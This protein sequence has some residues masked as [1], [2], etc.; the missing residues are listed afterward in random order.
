MPKSAE[1]GDP[2]IFFARPPL[3]IVILLITI[4]EP[5]TKGSAMAQDRE[6]PDAVIQSR[7]IKIQQAAKKMDG[8][9]AMF[10]VAHAVP[11]DMRALAD[12]I[13]EKATKGK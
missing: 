1:G 11:A 4:P 7:L 9:Q 12:L 13:E 5:L 10:L 3:A 6:P 8:P 2:Q